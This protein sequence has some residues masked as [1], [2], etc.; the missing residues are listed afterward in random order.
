MKLLRAVPYAVLI[1]YV[2][3]A[4]LLLAVILALRGDDGVGPA[5]SIA[6]SHQIHAGDLSLVCSHCHQHVEVSRHAGIPSTDVC[7]VC[8]ANVATDS[9]EIQT[10]TRIHETGETVAW[11]KIHEMPW[12]VYFTHKRHIRAEVDCAKCHGDVTVQL[13]VRQVRSLGMGMCVNCHR[14]NGASIDCWTCHK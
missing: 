12:H 4:A 1:G 2:A 6:F 3:A 11:V 9:P 10:L 8:H 7:M 5:Q 13:P 14:A